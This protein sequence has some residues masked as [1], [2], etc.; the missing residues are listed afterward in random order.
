MYSLSIKVSI[1]IPVFNTAKYLRECLDSAANQTLRDI[2]IICIDDGSTDGSAAICDEYA[3]RDSRFIVIHQEHSGQASVAR[4][5]GLDRATGEYIALLDSDDWI[6]PE[7]CQLMVQKAVEHD[8]DF[9]SC[10][11]CLKSPWKMYWR[12]WL[13]SGVQKN[14]TLTEKVKRA[15]CA[16]TG[17]WRIWKAS[18]IQKNHLRFH[19]GVFFEDV[20]FVVESLA[21]ANRVAV[22]FKQI[23]YYRQRE[24]SFVHTKR[25]AIKGVG[26]FD[27]MYQYLHKMP[28]FEEFKPFYYR[29]KWNSLASTYRRIRDQ[30][31]D[32]ITGFVHDIRSTA[33]DL[34][35]SGALLNVT[36]VSR[37]AQKLYRTLFV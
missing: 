30:E 14:P 19:E 20:P 11:S 2:E 21:Y 9:V 15:F 37:R 25:N 27:A 3:A 16:G 23:H 36:R 29:M 8:A 12:S 34:E 10:F 35:K 26:M 4:N 18:V 32:W 7:Y 6:K 1:I 33:T 24:D 17:P 31:P 22:V 28:C 5:R 13:Y